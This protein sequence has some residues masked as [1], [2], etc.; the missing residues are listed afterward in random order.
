M[1]QAEDPDGPRAASSSAAGRECIEWRVAKLHGT[2]SNYFQ[3]RLPTITQPHA[4]TVEYDSGRVFL[5]WSTALAASGPTPAYRIW[6]GDW[7]GA[8]LPFHPHTTATLSIRLPAAGAGEGSFRVEAIASQAGPS[9]AAPIPAACAGLHAPFSQKSLHS[10]G[11]LYTE[12]NA[13]AF[14]KRRKEEGMP[15]HRVFLVH[16]MGNH[17]KGWSK[18]VT[19]L[20]AGLYKQYPKLAEK[21]LDQRIRFHEINYDDI[22]RGLA[23]NWA[24][25]AAE[26]RKLITPGASPLL[27]NVFDELSAA[28][29]T[30]NNFIW[31]HAADVVLYRL[32]AEVRMAIRTTVAKQFA[33]GINEDLDARQTC[34]FSVLA[35][36]LG[37][38]VAHDSMHALMAGTNAVPGGRSFS[39][40]N[41]KAVCLMQIAN[42][43][44]LLE[45]GPDVYESHYRPGPSDGNDNGANY[46][47]NCRNSWDP[48]PVLRPFEPVGWPAEFF[49]EIT[50]RHVHDKNVHGF[51][52]YLK[53]PAVHIPF[54]RAATDD[55]GT[56]RKITRT[57]EDAAL[58]AFDERALPGA[59]AL[60]GELNNLPFAKSDTWEKIGE[61]AKWFE[62]ALSRV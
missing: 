23:D 19:G 3:E 56:P 58:Q 27:T 61:V 54:F 26:L 39:P 4:P 18:S 42:V 13:P 16:G 62:G 57:Q 6:S 33:E 38:A 29:T 7:P 53:H 43:S 51:E 37:T 28:A 25:R 44:R 14:W 49:R 34:R 32:A 1:I 47:F 50:V 2:N 30:D 20:L 15:I 8:R 9:F 55:L 22:F 40:R 45:T 21:P 17:P 12:S 10:A 46:F 60:V 52:H 35:H 11:R 59:L 36:S 41:V 31:S 24:A 48:F 5:K